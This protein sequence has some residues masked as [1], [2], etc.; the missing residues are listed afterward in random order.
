[1]HNQRVLHQQIARPSVH[2]NLGGA[3]LVAVVRTRPQE[4]DRGRAQVL[5]DAPLVR[6]GEI[7]H[8]EVFLIQTR[9]PDLTGDIKNE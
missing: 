4:P 3:I 5:P 6:T 2:R 9:V 1:M 7:P 8:A